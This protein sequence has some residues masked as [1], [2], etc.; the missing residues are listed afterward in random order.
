[1]KLGYR[2]SLEQKVFR[3]KQESKGSLEQKV[4]REKPEYKE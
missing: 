4:F 1:V 2:E 3:E